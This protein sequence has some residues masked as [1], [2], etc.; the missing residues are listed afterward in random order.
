MKGGIRRTT[1]LI[2]GYM[3]SRIRRASSIIKITF[4][5]YRKDRANLIVSAIS[6]YILLTF[7]PFTLLAISSIGYVIDL[8]DLD[9]HFLSYMA[10]IVPAPYNVSILRQ[11]SQALNVIDITKSLSGPLGLAALFFFTSKLF[12]VLI[13]S[14]QIIFRRHPDPFI[15]QKGK[16]LLFTL[17]FSIIQAIV[18]FSTVFLL[19]IKSRIAGIISDHM[20]LDE[21][22]VLSLFSFLD[23][24]FIFMMFALLY[25]MLTPARRKKALLF[26][27]TLLATI[28]WETGKY[29]FRYYALNVG[30][31]DVVFGLYGIF[32]GFLLWTYYS[33]FVFVVC[34][35]LQAVLLQGPGAKDTG[36]GARVMG[37]G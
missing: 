19:V 5:K 35:E 8:T 21:P 15:K 12:S 24:I 25:Y 37:Q 36:H 3:S 29:L 7:I 2:A 18:F 34:A 11:I 30:K 32:V 1:S 10:N 23:V 14:F 13:P 4:Q 22:A 26:G 28:F 27:T 17:L 16:E 33:V 6:F 9:E 31:F 20:Y